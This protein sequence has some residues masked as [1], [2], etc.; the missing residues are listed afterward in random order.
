MTYWLIWAVLMA[1]LVLTVVLNMF[2]LGV[3]GTVLGLIIACIKALLV[4]VFYMHLRHS[5][6]FIRL[7]AGAALLWICFMFALSWADFLS[8]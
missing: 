8:R 3:W 7:A 4:A 2:H 1:L 5:P 6:A